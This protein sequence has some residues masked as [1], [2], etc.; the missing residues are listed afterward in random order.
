[1]L[2]DE[3]LWETALSLMHL[4]YWAV[5]EEVNKRFGVIRIMDLFMKKV[6]DHTEEELDDYFIKLVDCIL[7]G[8]DV[9]GYPPCEG[10]VISSN[11]QWRKPL[12]WIY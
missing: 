9:L 8:L 1:M 4:Y 2:E 3:G 5:E 10:N 11:T 7:R 12:S 6:T